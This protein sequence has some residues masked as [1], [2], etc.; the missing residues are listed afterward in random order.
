MPS[1]LGSMRMQRKREKSKQKQVL[2]L[3][4]KPLYLVFSSLSN[5]PGAPHFERGFEVVHVQPRVGRKLFA[6]GD[7]H[8]FVLGPAVDLGRVSVEHR[9]PKHRAAS[10]RL[11]LI[12]AKRKERKEK[13]GNL[14][15]KSLRAC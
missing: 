14:K 11:H 4:L 6:L 15:G 10:F 9:R 2:L 7:R 3:E 1:R 5:L 8:G 12:V 13:K